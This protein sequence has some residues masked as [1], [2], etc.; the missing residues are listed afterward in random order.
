MLLYTF[1][2]PLPFRFGIQV[3]INAV[4]FSWDLEECK[5]ANALISTDKILPL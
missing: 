4:L 3:L 2:H 1:D 5:I